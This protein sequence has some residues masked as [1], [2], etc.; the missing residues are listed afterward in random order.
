MDMPCCLALKGGFHGWG[1]ELVPFC[2]SSRFLHAVAGA[3]HPPGGIA[4]VADDGGR[5]SL[6]QKGRGQQPSYVK[7]NPLK[8]FQKL[9]ELTQHWLGLCASAASSKKMLVQKF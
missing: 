2:S 9:V 1:R 4:D 5:F 7:S 6:A 8:Q 3:G